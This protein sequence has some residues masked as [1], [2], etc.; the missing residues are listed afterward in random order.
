MPRLFT[1][2]QTT[3]TYV[4]KLCDGG[5][6]RLEMKR[7]VQGRVL[8]T[9]L[10]ASL[11]L[12]DDLYFGLR[13][14]DARN[15]SRWLSLGKSL[16]QQL[17]DKSVVLHFNVRYYTLN[18]DCLEEE[19]A[20][21]YF[22]AQ[23]RQDI[24]LGRCP[25]SFGV[26]AEI[27]AYAVQAELGDY[28]PLVHRNNYVSKFRFV[29]DQTAQLERKI[30][31]NHVK[32]KGGTPAEMERCYLRRLKD[33]HYYGLH[34]HTCMLHGS[35][36]TSINVGASARG[37]YIF[38]G[39]IQIGYFP[40]NRVWELKYKKRQLTVEVADTM[41]GGG[42]FF[43]LEVPTGRECRL[44]WK[45]MIEQHYFFKREMAGWPHK[46]K[47]SIK[48]GAPVIQDDKHPV[49]RGPVAVDRTPSNNFVERHASIMMFNTVALSK[50]Q[51]VSSLDDQRH[52]HSPQ[53]LSSVH[54]TDRSIVM[55]TSKP[56]SSA[57]T[58]GS[59]STL[60]NP[61]LQSE[62]LSFNSK[63]AL[64]QK[65]SHGISPR[66]FQDKPLSLHE[67][68][69]RAS[70]QKWHRSQHQQ[71][72]EKLL[73]EY[74]RQSLSSANSP[75]V[76]NHQRSMS[77]EDCI[78]ENVKSEAIST[79]NHSFFHLKKKKA[80]SS[81]LPVRGTRSAPSSASSPPPASGVLSELNFNEK[82][83]LSCKEE[84]MFT[85]ADSILPSLS[86]GVA[87]DQYTDDLSTNLCSQPI[88]EDNTLHND[89]QDLSFDDFIG[90]DS[91]IDHT[92]KSDL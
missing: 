74:E 62:L 89:T 90:D 15:L 58:K 35:R 7:G 32:L 48:R 88:P 60:P 85:E 86:V 71:Q 92:V 28:N 67:Y 19:T 54:D 14:I 82:R 17:G 77:H 49:Q 2:Q 3:T 9:A 56:N 12:V 18:P 45:E 52:P 91:C 33:F 63:M 64:T 22:F 87:L 41:R 29:Q 27:C 31:D 50:R 21:Y 36:E 70:Q 24:K 13:F 61:F 57:T 23:L 53:S 65:R 5:E 47:T 76:M 38:S 44:L 11:H 39:S 59:S 83:N 16:Q 73:D 34:L 78:I 72:L 68:Q 51:S 81:R 80:T 55:S 79:S 42:L 6:R 1:K 20:R 40:W 46:G 4:I 26:L 25:L 8:M 84:D 43:L 30:A 37:V 75:F 69:R 66:G 10:C